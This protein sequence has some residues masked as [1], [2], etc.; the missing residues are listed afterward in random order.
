MEEVAHLQLE[1]LRQALVG[2]VAAWQL[3]SVRRYAAVGL[4]SCPFDSL[5]RDGLAYL[6]Y[7]QARYWK[8]TPS[9]AILVTGWTACLWAWG[10][11]RQLWAALR[12]CISW[13]TISATGTGALCAWA[14]RRGTGQRHRRLTSGGL[15]Y[16]LRTGRMRVTGWRLWLSEVW[17]PCSYP[18]LL[19]WNE[20]IWVS[21]IQFEI[22]PVSSRGVT[23]GLPSWW[24]WYSAGHRVVLKPCHLGSS[25]RLNPPVWHCLWN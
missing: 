22:P 4:S 15:S 18:C 14:S 9:Q 13:R 6:W 12:W 1:V 23:S 5:S 7:L 21:H 2:S 10:V 17:M 24:Y 16:R 19:D 11:Q 20:Q 8:S 3:A 25:T